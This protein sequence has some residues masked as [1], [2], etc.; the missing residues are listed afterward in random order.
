MK[1]EI[2]L[3]SRTGGAIVNVASRIGMHMRLPFQGAYA[4]SKAGVSVLTRN[5]AREYISQGIRVNAIAPGGVETP[6]WTDLPFFQELVEKTGSEAAAFQALG[7]MATPLGRYAK[8]EEIAEQVAF[9]LS[10]KAAFTTG[11]CLV[12]DGGYS[13]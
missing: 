1:C 4:A 12:S 3:M 5:A 7:G 10:E 2:C 6:I 9:L 13:L 8:P 11:A